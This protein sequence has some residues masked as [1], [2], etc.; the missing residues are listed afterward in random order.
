MRQALD[1]ARHNQDDGRTHPDLRVRRRQRD[2]QRT[3][4]R[5]EGGQEKRDAPATHIRNVAEQQGA[6]RPGNEADR[7][8]DQRINKRLRLTSA[9]PKE[10]ESEERGERCVNT[11]VEDFHRATDKSAENLLAARGLC[12]CGH[13]VFQSYYLD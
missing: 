12:L 13:E 1:H 7:K 4:Q 5:G 6:D 2:E 10:G 3:N 8:H 9:A 11:L